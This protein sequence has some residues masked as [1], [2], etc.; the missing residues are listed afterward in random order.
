M[1]EKSEK[2]SDSVIVVGGNH[3]TCDPSYFNREEI[4][5]IVIGVGKKSFSELISRIQKGERGDGDSRHCKN[6]SR[7]FPFLPAEKLRR[8]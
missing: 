5:Y 4:D 3:A 6:I 8:G 1:P 2:I 7:L